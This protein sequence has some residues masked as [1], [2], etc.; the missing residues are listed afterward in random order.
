M[1]AMNDPET[2]APSGPRPPPGYGPLTPLFA[3]QHASLTFREGADFGFARNLQTV[4]LVAAEFGHALSNFPILF[5]PKAPHLPMALM[6]LTTNQNDFVQ[7]DGS[8]PASAHLPLYLQ[9]YPFAIGKNSDGQM[10]LAADLAAPHFEAGAP[11]A[12]LLFEDGKPTA[13][14]E[15][16]IQRCRTFEQALGETRNAVET[17]AK[18]RLLEPASIRFARKDGEAAEMSGFLAVAPERMREL[19]DQ[20]LAQLAR[21]GLVDLAAAHRISIA[22]LSSIQGARP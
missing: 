15:A 9:R 16:A 3:A 8:W 18:H 2:K 5:Q 17:L 19:D 13:T 12:Q 20:T 1:P 10:L 14:T 4:P 21:N 7:A 22:R 6:G 11:D